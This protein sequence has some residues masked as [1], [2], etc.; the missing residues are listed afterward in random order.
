MSGEIQALLNEILGEVKA[1]RAEL[2][3]VQGLTKVGAAFIKTA[4]APENPQDEREQWLASM[5]RDLGWEAAFD[6][7]SGGE[8]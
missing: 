2:Q 5:K 3:A 6:K 8:L 1:L 4:T 7:A